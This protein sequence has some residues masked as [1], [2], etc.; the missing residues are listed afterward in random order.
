MEEM[1]GVD[2]DVEVGNNPAF[3]EI[4]SAI[5]ENKE[6]RGRGGDALEGV[7]SFTWAQ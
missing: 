4:N 6:I 3:R 7:V 5:I 2:G 1:D